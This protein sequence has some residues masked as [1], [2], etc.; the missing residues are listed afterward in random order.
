MPEAPLCL[1]SKQVGKIREYCSKWVEARTVVR[2]R[3]DAYEEDYAAFE[4][5]KA[6]K[7]NPTLLDDDPAGRT[8]FEKIRDELNGE[9]QLDN[10]CALITDGPDKARYWAP[11]DIAAVMNRNDTTITRRLKTIGKAPSAD[12]RGRLKACTHKTERPPV[13][14]DGIFDVLMDW[15]AEYYLKSTILGPHHYK[16][17]KISA[18][19]EHRIRSFW[20][21]T[22]DE[23]RREYDDR[24]AGEPEVSPEQEEELLRFVMDLSDEDRPVWSV[25]FPWD[26]PSHRGDVPDEGEPRGAALG[27]FKDAFTEL[28]RSMSHWKGN[29]SAAALLTIYSELS[30]ILSSLYAWFPLIALL[31]LTACF[32]CL[33]YRVPPRPF[34]GAA[35][36][37][38]I[39][40]LGLWVL[41]F[42]G[43]GFSAENPSPLMRIPLMKDLQQGIARLEGI[44]ARRTAET[45][46]ML[47]EALQVTHAFLLERR[48][49]DTPV[50]EAEYQQML[51]R[52][53]ARETPETL[54]PL[55]SELR[56]NEARIYLHWAFDDYRSGLTKLQAA[57]QL[58][59][60]TREELTLAGRGHDVLQGRTALA[61]SEVLYAGMERGLWGERADE[62]IR[63]ADMASSLLRDRE[64]REAIAA[65][66][67][68]SHLLY[69]RGGQSI[70]PNSA[71][72]R[73]AEE[74]ARE[75]LALSAR[76]EGFLHAELALALGLA[77]SAQENAREAIQ[78]FTDGLRHTDMQLQ[79][80]LYVA[81]SAALA[82][83]NAVLCLGTKDPTSRR[84][85]EMALSAAF[86]VMNRYAHL[87]SD[88]FLHFALARASLAAGL[89]AQ[90]GEDLDQALSSVN[91]VLDVWTF[92]PYTS[93]HIQAA[94]TKAAI[95][96][97]MTFLPKKHEDFDRLERAGSEMGSEAG[98]MIRNAARD[99]RRTRILMDQA[100]NREALRK[101][102]Q[103]LEQIAYYDRT[104]PTLA[105]K[106][107][108]DLFNAYLV[109]AEAHSAAGA[110]DRLFGPE[111]E[112]DHLAAAER[113]IRRARELAGGQGAKKIERAES[114]LRRVRLSSGAAQ[115]LMRLSGKTSQDLMG[116]T[117]R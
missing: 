107:A 96:T 54:R 100:V 21:E 110:M 83:A 6:E 33:R 77:L 63:A 90:N 42:V 97:G 43:R 87:T 14:S 111:D 80:N 44:E 101:A 116:R 88:A 79:P 9:F 25:R 13:Y 73:H 103:T 67:A 41:C 47:E 26:R 38:A 40:F 27:G 58:L 105:R 64:P 115:M 113:A 10:S 106:C 84:E 93:N 32:L 66:E 4:K 62:A 30:Y 2:R 68:R 55:R 92:T 24:K 20:Q 36:S 8:W 53:E 3:M 74:A 61:L 102:V 39:L 112:E 89:A 75:G 82:D 50:S 29:L 78:A 117:A 108:T 69:F 52:T 56:V 81:L 7:G 76:N 34:W 11:K 31:V 99:A 72:L 104:N 57:E 18:E 35:G 48:R 85:A 49:N 98:D 5:E 1:S 114:S 23:A 16:G 65:Q 71:D 60:Q 86:G 46:A 70:D 91:R 37:T 59:L 19:D 17:E 15:K 51:R 28:W 22:M 109:L 95:L 94:Y 12:W 45:Q